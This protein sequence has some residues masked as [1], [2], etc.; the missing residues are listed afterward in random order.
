MIPRIFKEI[1]YRG[2]SYQT[3]INGIKEYWEKKLQ[4]HQN[5][6]GICYFYYS[7]VRETPFYPLK[8]FWRN[9]TDK[10]QFNL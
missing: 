5:I 6:T 3:E 9:A 8:I 1:G 2:I 10:I 7:L 4:K